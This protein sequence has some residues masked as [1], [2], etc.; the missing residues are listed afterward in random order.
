MLTDDGYSRRG[1]FALFAIGYMVL[2]LS[3]DGINSY[4]LR[5]GEFEG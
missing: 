2:T 3:T 1:N 4:G 5:G